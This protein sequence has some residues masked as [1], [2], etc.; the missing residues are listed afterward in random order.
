MQLTSIALTG[1]AVR[2]VP[3]G[4]ESLAPVVAAALSAPAV[5]THIPWRMGDAPE[6]FTAQLLR[7]IVGLEVRI[8]RLEGKFKLSQN[9]PAADQ[10]GVLAGLQRQGDAGSMALAEAMQAVLGGRPGAQSP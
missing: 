4:S 5:W 3:L 9:R 8:T 7:A 6:D 1:S 2:L 10:Q